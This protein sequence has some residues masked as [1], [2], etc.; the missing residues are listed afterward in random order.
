VPDE[1]STRLWDELYVGIR[2]QCQAPIVVPGQNCE[3]AAGIEFPE[4]GADACLTSP[5]N[6]RE[7]LARV[8]SSLRRYTGVRQSASHGPSKGAGS[9]TG[10]S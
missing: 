6:M 3:G 10:I 5:L 1:C 9:F 4:M 2:E 8:R 7:L